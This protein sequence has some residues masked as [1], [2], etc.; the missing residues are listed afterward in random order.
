MDIASILQGAS[1][2]LW[3]LAVGILVL[4]IMRA[5]NNRPIRK[6]GLIAACLIVFAAVVSLISAG[7]VFIEPQERGIVISAFQ[8]EG[9]RQ[10]VL[11]PGLHWIIPF[12]EYVVRYP[13]SRQTYTMSV[14]SSEGAVQGD[15][16]ITAR[17]QDGQQIYVDASVIFAIDPAKVIQ[18]HIEWQNRYLDE[19]VRAQSRG[20]I[21]DAVAKYKVDE[22]ISSMRGDMVNDITSTLRQKLEENGF[23]LVDFVL[24][25]ITF[26]D[27][28]A[29]SV[30][31]KQIAEQQAL[32]ARFVVE[33]KKQEAEQAREVAKGAAD[34]VVTR[35]EGD[36]KARLIQAEAEAKALQMIADVL[37]DNPDLLSYQYIT[38]LAPDIQV[39]LLPSGSPFILPIPT[40]TE[41][42]PTESTTV[43]PTPTPTV[44]P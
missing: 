39:M 14:A 3:L 8:P 5:S 44:V 26:S 41:T 36:A 10:D 42:T 34:A 21:R 25:N 11:E 19:L 16:S 27:E 38:K 15:D 1:I 6:G 37:K 2:A 4:V 32:Q 18:V 35:A 31:Q 12:G 28:Y 43:S 23:I 17:T 13:I 40:M 20:I 29:A 22:V 7:L 24:R 9:Y 33:S 30:E